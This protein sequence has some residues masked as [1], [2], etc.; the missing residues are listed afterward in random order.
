[1]LV[2]SVSVISILSR[3]SKWHTT[4]LLNTLSLKYPKLW[5]FSGYEIWSHL[6]VL[7][8]YQLDLFLL[9]SSQFLRE[10]GTQCCKVEVLFSGF[11]CSRSTIHFQHRVEH[12]HEATGMKRSYS[13]LQCE[14]WETATKVTPQ[15]NFSK[16][17]PI[18]EFK[19][20]S[21]CLTMEAKKLCFVETW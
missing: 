3:K 15:E 4:E 21:V 19:F 17:Y 13:N 9:D 1:M 10:K 6:R 12:L 11:Q 16:R 18:T 8:C 20:C 5:I 14:R 7:Y 2:S